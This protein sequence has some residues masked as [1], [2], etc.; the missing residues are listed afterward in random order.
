MLLRLIGIGMLSSLV[1]LIGHQS[2]FNC[3]Y[4]VAKCENLPYSKANTCWEAIQR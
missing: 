2:G 3:G 4:S 1:Y